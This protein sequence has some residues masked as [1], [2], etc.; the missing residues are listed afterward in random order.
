M[1]K[2]KFPRTYTFKLTVSF[3]KGCRAAVALREVRDNI[4]GEHYCTEYDDNDPG[5]FRVSSIKAAKRVRR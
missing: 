1:A 4:H 3:N 2:R 5:T